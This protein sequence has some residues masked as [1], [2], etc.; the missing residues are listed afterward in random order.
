MEARNK[1]ERKLLLDSKKD[2]PSKRPYVE[3][4]SSIH[5]LLEPDPKLAP[6]LLH[7]VDYLSIKETFH[8][9]LASK[10]FN[11]KITQSE[12]SDEHIKKF[13]IIK[14]NNIGTY[15]DLFTKLNSEYQEYATRSKCANYGFSLLLCC[16]CSLGM[17]AAFGF[18]W[19]ITPAAAI[20][21]KVFTGSLLLGIAGPFWGGYCAH[22][23]GAVVVSLED[24]AGTSVFT[25]KEPEVLRMSK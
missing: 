2:K 18:G 9:A 16:A 10:S 4:T 6:L 14:K 1:G 19:L 22:Q 12:I 3:S 23:T 7:I 21:E 17:S 15:S 25:P 20:S 24:C 11:E 8:L 5:K 13:P